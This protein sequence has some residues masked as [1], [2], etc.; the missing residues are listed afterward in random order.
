M[1]RAISRRRARGAGI[2]CGGNWCNVDNLGSDHVRLSLEVVDYFV[3]DAVAALNFVLL[4]LDELPFR[5]AVQDVFTE[6][7]L[8][9]RGQLLVIQGLLHL[10]NSLELEGVEAFFVH[11]VDFSLDFI[12]ALDNLLSARIALVLLD[13]EL[14]DVYMGGDALI[15]YPVRQKRCNHEMARL[16]RIE[17]VK[18]VIR[19]Y[20]KCVAQPKSPKTGAAWVPPGAHTSR[21]HPG[22]IIDCHKP[23]M[24]AVDR[25]ITH[26]TG[27]VNN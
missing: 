14:G 8:G 25:T 15:T 27:A 11:Y 17:L 2:G 4:S 5:V 19:V 18:R 22:K 20:R 24:T 13:G 1:E 7:E 10:G 3:G 23:T 6:P 9:F 21:R 26:A 12:E 16:K